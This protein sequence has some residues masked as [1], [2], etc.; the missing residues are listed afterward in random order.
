[1]ITPLPVHNKHFIFLTQPSA[2]LLALY[3]FSDLSTAKFLSQ[4]Y[5]ARVSYADSIPSHLL[6]GPAAPSTAVS[7]PYQHKYSTEMFS[8]PRPQYV[9]SHS[10][11]DD[12][13]LIDR[14]LG[15]FYD[16]VAQ[17]AALAKLEGKTVR[18]TLRPRKL[19]P[20][21]DHQLGFFEQGLVLGASLFLTLVVSA[22]GCG[23]WIWRRPT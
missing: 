19:Q 1:V 18:K 22:V 21:G 13:T 3:T 15:G 8:S 7:A 10:A 23:I 2:N 17:K 20:E 16:S 9:T 5:N 12:L 11:S 4:H 14:L 6:V